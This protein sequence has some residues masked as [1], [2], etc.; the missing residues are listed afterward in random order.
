MIA[1]ETQESTEQSD[2]WDMDALRES[3]LSGALPDASSPVSPI[4]TG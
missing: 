3:R 2:F 4:S 1:Q